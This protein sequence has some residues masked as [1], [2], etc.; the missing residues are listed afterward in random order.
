M[1]KYE[2]QYGCLN[3]PLPECK[4]DISRNPKGNVKEQNRRYKEKHR[5]EIAAKRR[6]QLRRYKEALR[7]C[8]EMGI[9]V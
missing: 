6:E 3:C 1:C 9:E 2:K 4:F 5:E 8:E 7:I